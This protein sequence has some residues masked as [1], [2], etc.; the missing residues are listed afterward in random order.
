MF[1]VAME[2]YSLADCTSSAFPANNA[3]SD[4]VSSP[5]FMYDEMASSRTDACPC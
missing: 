5:P 3:A 2:S 4:P 1:P